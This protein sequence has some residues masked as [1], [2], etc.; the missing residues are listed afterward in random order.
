MSV[1]VP[2]RLAGIAHLAHLP[3]LAAEGLA[4]EACHGHAEVRECGVGV[5]GDG[6]RVEVRSTLSLKLFKVA[7]QRLSLCIT[8]FF[9]I[10]AH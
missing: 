1:S 2:G 3:H 7:F 10:M 8:N 6:A 9:G 4:G 5:R